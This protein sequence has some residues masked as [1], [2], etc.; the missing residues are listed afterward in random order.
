MAA[1]DQDI[2]TLYQYF[3]CATQLKG[4]FHKAIEAYG[5]PSTDAKQAEVWLSS[6]FAY[7]SYFFAGLHVVLEGW[8]RLRLSDPEIDKLRLSP[9]V[10]LL[11]RYRNGAFHFQ[12]DYFDARYKDFVA[13][14]KALGTWADNLHEAFGRFF[15]EWNKQRGG[16]ST[17]TESQN[18]DFELNI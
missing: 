5:W 12:R 13:N 4:D 10:E 7:V 17:V 11:R 2:H 8:M 16:T 15:T 18:D 3:C 1:T 9:H 14:Y 6:P